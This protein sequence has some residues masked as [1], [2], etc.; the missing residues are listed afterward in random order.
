MQILLY[1][2]YVVPMVSTQ[3]YLYIDPGSKMVGSAIIVNNEQLHFKVGSKI[4]LGSV[5]KYVIYTV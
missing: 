4:C 2:N 1:K 5:V 3:L